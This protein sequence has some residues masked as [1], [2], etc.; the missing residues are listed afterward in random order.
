VCGVDGLQ[1][2]LTFCMGNDHTVHTSINQ[3][4]NE[5]PQTMNDWIRGPV[6]K[7]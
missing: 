1:V 4:I 2:T 6:T 5:I 7:Y 3:S